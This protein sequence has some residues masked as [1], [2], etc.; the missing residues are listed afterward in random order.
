V[1]PPRDASG[2]SGILLGF[3]HELATL[4][5]KLVLVP[6]SQMD[7]PHPS[8]NTCTPADQNKK[9]VL[10]N[11]ARLDSATNLNVTHHKLISV[12]T[13]RNNRVLWVF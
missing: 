13:E 5:L 9:Y 2:R 7:R 6:L 11:T 10:E 3:R 4:Y 12:C 8:K 1:F